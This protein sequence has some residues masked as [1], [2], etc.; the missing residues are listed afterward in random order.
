MNRCTTWVLIAV[1]ASAAAA[2]EVSRREISVQTSD[3]GTVFANVYGESTDAVVL[4]HGAVFNKESWHDLAICLAGEGYQV[5][6]IDFRGYGKSTAGSTSGGLELD[7]LAAVRSLRS[8]GAKTVS[9][10]GG[11]MGGAAA[12]RAS[13]LATPKEIDS[14][15]L[16]SPAS[17]PNPK[18]LKAKRFIYIASEG[19]GLARRLRQIHK[20][21]PDPKEIHLLPGN[22]HAQHIFKTSQSEALTSLIVASLAKTKTTTLPAGSARKTGPS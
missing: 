4:A 9:V 13:A 1:M 11:S 3:G 7:I 2:D 22:A 19:E 17:V 10:L 18:T 12:A 16:L 5:V 21:S 20:D 6:A 15:I 8:G 14:L